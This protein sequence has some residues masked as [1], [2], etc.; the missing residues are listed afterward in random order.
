MLIKLFVPHVSKFFI[1]DCFGFFALSK[2]I[3]SSGM[4]TAGVS[5]Y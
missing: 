1:V 4:G 3:K 2:L 5:I